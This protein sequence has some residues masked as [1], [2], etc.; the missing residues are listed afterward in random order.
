VEGIESQNRLSAS[1]P[2]MLLPTADGLCAINGDGSG[3]THLVSTTPDQHTPL[4]FSVSPDG[5]SLAYVLAPWD[6]S[7]DA[8]AYQLNLV[9]LPDLSTRRLT[10]LVGED[11]LEAIATEFPEE[12]S[13]VFMGSSLYQRLQIS[14]ALVKAGSIAWSPDGSRIAFVAALDGVSADVYVYHVD[15]D[16]ITRLTSGATQAA[17]LHWSPDS[18]FVSHQAISDINIGR[19][20]GDIIRGLWVARADGSGNRLALQGP[21][22]FLRWLDD[23]YFLGYFSEMGCGNYDLSLVRAST[24]ERQLIWNGQFDAADADPV[25]Q[26]VMIA[27]TNVDERLTLWDRC[28][29]PTEEGL[30]AVHPPFTTTQRVDPLPGLRWV[31]QL[32]WRESSDSFII[33]TSG[34]TLEVS[35]EGEV[36]D[37][38]HDGPLSFQVSPSRSWSLVWGGYYEVVVGSQGEVIPMH[39]IECNHFWHPSADTLFYYYSHEGETALYGASAPDFTPVQLTRGITLSCSEPPQ[40]VQ[41]VHD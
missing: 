5:S 27:F 29:L 14:A 6:D 8:A 25:S 12:S 22:Y 21:A 24:G 36:A 11:Q 37:Q 13:D 1:G 39:H 23:D 10:Q 38:E 9:T 20:G 16:V 19:S 31:D 17:D 33:H 18:Q 7:L 41:P 2:W 30:F 3:L 28:P 4:P 34:S 40:W 15:R 32:E 26:T 35:L